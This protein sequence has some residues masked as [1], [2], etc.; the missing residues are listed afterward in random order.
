M[1]PWWSWLFC[2]YA[3]APLRRCAVLVR[4]LVPHAGVFVMA[5]GSWLYLKEEIPRTMWLALTVCLC[6]SAMVLLGECP[7]LPTLPELVCSAVARLGGP[8]LAWLP[9]PPRACLVGAPA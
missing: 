1:N 5:G 6:G 8:L 7:S 4:V 2:L 9:P 3:V